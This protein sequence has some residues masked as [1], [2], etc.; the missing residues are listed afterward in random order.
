CSL[1]RRDRLGLRCAHLRSSAGLGLLC[2]R[3]RFA[4]AAWFGPPR[5]G[6]ARHFAAP[7]GRRADGFD[8]RGGIEP[9][10]LHDVVGRRQCH[11]NDD[12]RSAC[13]N[14]APHVITSR[15]LAAL[16]Q[17]VSTG[18]PCAPA[19]Q[20]PIPSPRYINK[21]LSFQSNN[22]APYRIAGGFFV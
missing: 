12:D 17:R 8:L 9:P 16:D 15:A 10:A 5:S 22:A 21:I 1:G 20:K 19:S 18:P 2:Q 6:F 3:G 11:R 4:P 14:L 13:D 7:R